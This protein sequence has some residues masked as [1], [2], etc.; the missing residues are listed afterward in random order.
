[1]KKEE[2]ENVNDKSRPVAF[3]RRGLATL[4][5]VGVGATV[6]FVVWEAS[7]FFVPEGVEASTTNFQ[8]V[9]QFVGQTVAVVVALISAFLAA[10]AVAKRIDPTLVWRKRR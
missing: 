3:G 1:M 10:N 2:T 4:I 9:L 7:S 8:M 5:G 6:F